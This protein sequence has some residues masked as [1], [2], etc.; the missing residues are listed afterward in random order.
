MLRSLTVLRLL[1]MFNESPCPFPPSAYKGEPY[2]SA[3]SP[4][5]LGFHSLFCY[6]LPL[7][8][9]RITVETDATVPNPLSRL[10]RPTVMF[11]VP[12][13]F[14]V[15]EL[16]CILTEERLSY[17]CL[18]L[19]VPQ[20]SKARMCVLDSY[21]PSV[22]NITLCCSFVFMQYYFPV[23]QCCRGIPSSAA[24]ERV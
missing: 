2:L 13:N 22:V 12:L 8:Q 24:D 11:A 16:V 1:S 17:R 18:F 14:E 6:M 9:H 19:R 15:V 7:H 20:I 5:W 23:G 4:L 3:R 21:L 10:N